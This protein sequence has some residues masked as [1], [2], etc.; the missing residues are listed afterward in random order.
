[1]P[2]NRPQIFEL[3][4]WMEAKKINLECESCNQ[5]E[6]GW[7]EIVNIPGFERDN[8]WTGELLQSI[9]F[10]LV[11]KN[12]GYIRFYSAMAVKTEDGFGL[13]LQMPKD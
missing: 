2:V 5:T 3:N 8:S 7:N 10:Q 11:C 6:W 9:A 1:M 13:V 4:K 12:C